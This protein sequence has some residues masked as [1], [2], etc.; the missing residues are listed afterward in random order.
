MKTR[1]LLIFSALA[2]F[3]GTAARAQVP[4]DYR[5]EVIVAGRHM[6]TCPEVVV[7]GKRV[8]ICDTAIIDEAV[9]HYM[10]THVPGF[11]Q[12]NLPNFIITGKN[13]KTL[14]GIGGYVNFRTAYDFMGIV[15]NTDF[16]TYDIP[17]PGNYA[18]RQKLRMDASTTRLFFKAIYNSD[19]L[20][21]ITTYIETDFRG[22]DHKNLRLRQAYISFKGWLF[23]RDVSTFCDLTASPNLIDFEGPSSYNFSFNQMI[24]YTHSFNPSWTI[25]AAL[26]LPD[27]SATYSDDMKPIPQRLP[28]LPVYLQ[29]NFG[30]D[31]SSHLR[32][33]A[34]F[35]DLW[36][37]D[38]ANDRTTTNFGW[39]VQLSGN[40]TIGDKVSL[41][42]QGVYGKGITPY[43]Q[44]I[45][46]AGLDLV[47][48][49][50]NTT[51][52]Q[53]LPMY[54]FFGAAQYNFTRKLFVSGGYSQVRVYNQNDYP[55]P[56]Q[57]KYA[58]Y[59]F[60]NIF[61]TISPNFQVAMEYL[62]GIRTNMN[63]DK[64]HANRIQA[65]IQFNF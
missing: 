30:K 45:S 50:A 34:V 52:L 32:A 42:M 5:P 62:R 1:R 65:M 13:N 14:L 48:N 27:L 25:G 23:G 61:Y 33:S 9:R 29:W 16:V 40:I 6:T 64:N 55:M 47:P 46:G 21:R 36:Y 43:I 24:R 57:Y 2:L 60:G 54:G 22:Y 28:D 11:Q 31:K 19:R 15:Q 41:F 58:Q 49:P 51:R 56:E 39:G 59:I 37:H 38:A 3:C 44:D 4:Y 63:H 26:E 12:S 8:V 53:T 17:V 7:A 35:R 10:E 18:T 20:G